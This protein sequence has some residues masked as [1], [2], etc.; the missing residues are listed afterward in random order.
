MPIRGYAKLCHY[1]IV[2]AG[3]GDITDTRGLVA[4]DQKQEAPGVFTATV[5]ARPGRL[6]AL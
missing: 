2:P 6:S 4:A 1:N 5:R 3:W